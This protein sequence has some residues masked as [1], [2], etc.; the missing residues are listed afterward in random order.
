MQMAAEVVVWCSE[1][2]VAWPVAQS[3]VVIDGLTVVHFLIRSLTDP[4]EQKTER[5]GDKGTC[6]RLHSRQRPSSDVDTGDSGPKPKFSAAACPCPGQLPVLSEA[7]PT[8]TAHTMKS[9]PVVC[10]FIHKTCT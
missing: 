10:S 3:P 2:V 6:S 7:T 8:L 1:L 5:G 4:M 9:Q